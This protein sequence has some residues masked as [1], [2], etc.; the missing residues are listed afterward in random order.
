MKNIFKSKRNIL[1]MMFA[2]VVIMGI[3]FA[4]YSQQLQIKD[5]SSIDS[6]WNV[7]IK[8]VSV[9]DKSSS[10]TGSGAVDE[11]TNL[12][13]DLKTDLK[14]PGDYVIYKLIVAN[15]GNIDAV[16]EKINFSMEKEGTVIKYYYSVDDKNTWNEV[17]KNGE[18]PYNEDLLAKTTDD[19]YVKVEYDP[20]KTGTAKEEEKSNTLTLEF[21]YAQKTGSGVVPSV[22][23]AAEMLKEKVTTTG[24]GLYEDEY[25]EGRH[26][27]KGANPNNYITFNEENDGAAGWRIF[28]VE[29][30][31]TIKILKKDSIGNK[32]FD[33][34]GRRDSTSNGAGGTYCAKYW[35]GCN[36]WS[37]NDN[38]VNESMIGTVLIDSEI[39]EFL[40]NDYYDGKIT[41]GMA[42]KSRGL[43]VSNKFNVG[44]VLFANSD[45][46]NQIISE[47]SI[48]W[49]G[50]IGL[51]T[52]SEI[53]RSNSNE[54]QCR[55]LKLNSENA[56]LCKATSYISAMGKDLWTMSPS[57]QSTD[58]QNVLY[59]RGYLGRDSVTQSYGIY[60]ALYLKSDITLSGSG[61][62]DDPY[63]I[64]S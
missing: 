60:P 34:K 28:S 5:T 58:M 21:I 22:P 29:A 19:F 4:A 59:S 26:V 17:S 64:N 54:T 1:I 16:L 25:E 2:L 43:I 35:S 45:L 41:N 31:G 48:T 51:L 14:Y 63:I 49:N 46:N 56:D 6:D 42:E 30:D 57:T 13:A 32:V 40:N 39:N 3:G 52:A 9:P 50:G 20:T 12:K 15:D 7:Y 36:A 8:D 18:N 53:L 37:I 11:T 47:N 44:P 61:T 24:D 27:Y 62:I 23:T 10:A 38:F 33:S 55:N